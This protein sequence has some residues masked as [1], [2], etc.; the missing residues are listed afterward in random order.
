M[1]L[2]NEIV[3]YE[4]GE[5]SAVELIAFFQKL[6]DTDMA[7]NLQGT[8]GRIARNLIEDGLCEPKKEK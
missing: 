7:W 1:K 6:I 4:N 2:V 8:Y 3:R 5:M